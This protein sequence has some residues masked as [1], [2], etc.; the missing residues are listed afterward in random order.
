MIFPSQTIT[1][2]LSSA[3][4]YS[5]HSHFAVPFT[6]SLMHACAHTCTK[7]ST[8]TKCSNKGILSPPLSHSHG[9]EIRALLCW[10]GSIYSIHLLLTDLW[11]KC[12]G[13]RTDTDKAG[14]EMCRYKRLA[15]TKLALSFNP[16]LPEACRDDLP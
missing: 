8:S 13:S 14:C 5:S 9:R 4:R 1:S 7:T 2:T 10:C 11:V 15:Q 3:Q 6:F 16:C 12:E